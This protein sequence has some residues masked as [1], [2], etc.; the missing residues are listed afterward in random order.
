VTTT[1]RSFIQY[2][3]VTL[4]AMLASS[5][6]PPTCY[7]PR[8]AS[9]PTPTAFPMPTCYAPPAPTEPAAEAGEKWD[10]LRARWL[11]LRNPRL[12]SPDGD[13][14]SHDLLRRH[15]EALS[16]LQASGG[17]DDDVAAA[18]AVAF[19]QAFAHVQRK[20]ATCYE[21]LQPGQPNPYTS[22]ED[23]TTQAAALAEM[24]ERS[25]IDPVTI[26]RAREALE[27][28]LAW[29]ARFQTRSAIGDAGAVQP[30]P[31]EIEAARLLVELLLSPDSVA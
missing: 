22:R 5:C 11:D 12:G 28:D 31:A 29:L 17:P 14:F 30:P 7:I 10:A 8:T 23:L 19:E 15:S 6:L 9:T 26:A 1:R 21:P 18:M 16:A 3:G 20:A 13:A 4:G 2:V 27:R 25:A 24:A